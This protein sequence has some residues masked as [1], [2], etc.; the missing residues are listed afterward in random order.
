MNV[1]MYC[2][3]LSP[4]A[5]FYPSIESHF[6][7]KLHSDQVTHIEYI[8]KTTQRWMDVLQTSSVSLCLQ[9]VASVFLP[10]CGSFT[11]RGRGVFVDL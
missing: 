2:I 10:L 3:Y 6:N 7:V 5:L 4:L 11:G 9:S 1:Q 8:K